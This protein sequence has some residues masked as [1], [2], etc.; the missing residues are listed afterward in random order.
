M[1]HSWNIAVP[2][3]HNADWG[4]EITNFSE[5]S[6]P[7]ITLTFDRFNHEEA[8]PVSYSVADQF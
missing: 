5:K 1:Q 3:R 2:E 8:M 6:M 7:S 4:V